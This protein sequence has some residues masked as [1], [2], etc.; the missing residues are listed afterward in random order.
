M[1]TLDP[2][3]TR[4]DAFRPWLWGAAATLLALP[5]VAMQFTEEV[6]WTASDFVA[7]G[8]LL[9]C[10]CIAY[11][12]ATRISDHRL[13]QLG[14]GLAIGSAFLLIWADLA[15]GY[16]GEGSN[17]VN[18]SVLAIPVAAWLVALFGRFTARGMARAMF[19][20]AAL[21]AAVTVA[22]PLAGYGSVLPQSLLFIALWSTAAQC[23]RLADVPPSARARPGSPSA[24]APSP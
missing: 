12:L 18:E 13:Y 2:S 14:A 16:A 24:A 6:R 10:V 15:V 4:T 11:E 9:A 23:F 5:A 7:M 8:V 20:A 1:P 17:I 3:S 19:S 22:A 21:Q